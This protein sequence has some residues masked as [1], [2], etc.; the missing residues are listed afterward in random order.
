MMRVGQVIVPMLVAAAGFRAAAA[1]ATYTAICDASAAAPIG[2]S[3]FV[4]ANDE[5]NVLRIYNRTGG[6]P[7]GTVDLT[8][9]LDIKGDSPE[10]DI[11]AAA[12][13][14]KRIYWLTSHGRNKNGKDRPNRQQFFATD[15]QSLSVKPVG[16]AFHGLLKPLLDP[17][18]GLSAVESLAP[19]EGGINIEGMASMPDGSLLIG[20]RS[21][22][23]EQKALLVFLM[24]PDAVVNGTA[25]PSLS[26][27][28]HADLEGLGVRSMEYDPSRKKVLILAG[29]AGSSGPFKLF[30]WSQ[31][32]G[33]KKL[34]DVPTKPEAAPEGMFLQNNKLFVVFD[35]G[36]RG[37]PDCK[38]TSK[39]S[40][41]STVINLN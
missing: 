1:E 4:V 28:L 34:K 22:L 2:A 38:E 5:D 3:H 25:E 8:K 37:E 26:E 20:F 41:S 17:K 29:P 40:F 18:Y 19:E 36:D 13:I 9:F 33:V 10:A 31:E 12:V 16:K 14:G 6:K 32:E 35:E 21:P 23:Q 7:V 15:I 11:E 39:K 30:E 27:P 24:N